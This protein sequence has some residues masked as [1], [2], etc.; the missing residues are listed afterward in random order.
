MKKLS[1]SD[2]EHQASANGRASRWLQTDLADFIYCVRLN[3]QSDAVLERLWFF[4]RVRH[5]HVCPSAKFLWDQS[6]GGFGNTLLQQLLPIR[7]P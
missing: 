1:W 2:L 6:I 5:R 3:E 4:Q 7:W